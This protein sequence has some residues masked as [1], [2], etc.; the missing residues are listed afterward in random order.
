MAKARSQFLKEFLKKGNRVGAVA[1]SGRFLIRKML[2]GLDLPNAKVVVELGPGEGCI[3]RELIPMLGPETRLFVFEM[4]ETFVEEFLQFDDPRV[5]V[6]CDSAEHIDKHLAAAGV[7]EVDSIISSLPLA[8]FPVPLKEKIID[9]SIRALKPGGIYR[10]YQYST[11]AF[12]L[13]KSKFQRVKLD[14]TPFNIPPAFV[15]TCFK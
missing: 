4:S 14:Y 7:K 10:Q 6:I 1:P 8:I 13:L 3:T 9:E 11:S 5:T 12:R 2:K 15:Y